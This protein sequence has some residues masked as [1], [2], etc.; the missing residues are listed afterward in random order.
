M[1]FAEVI[2]ELE[3]GLASPQRKRYLRDLL[4]SGDLEGQ[5]GGSDV[6]PKRCAAPRPAAVKVDGRQHPAC[7]SQ[8]VKP[9]HRHA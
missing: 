4:A 7:S 2:Q 5:P 1:T 9:P 6:H 3:E 8:P